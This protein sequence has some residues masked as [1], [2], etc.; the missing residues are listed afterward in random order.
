V[1]FRHALLA[2]EIYQLRITPVCLRKRIEHVAILEFEQTHDK[3]PGS[4]RLPVSLSGGN[5]LGQG[6]AKDDENRK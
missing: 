6:T 1:F 2:K 3:H 4:L 5:S